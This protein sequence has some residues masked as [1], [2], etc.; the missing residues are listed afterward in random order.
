MP[1]KKTSPDGGKGRWRLGGAGGHSDDS[2]GSRAAF[3]ADDVSDAIAI[4]PANGSASVS[5]AETFDGTA[6]RTYFGLSLEYPRYQLSLLQTP[7][8][9][10]ERRGAKEQGR[11]HDPY[12]LNRSPTTGLQKYIRRNAPISGRT[13]PIC[14]YCSEIVVVFRSNGNPPRTPT[15]FLPRLLAKIDPHRSLHRRD[16]RYYIIFCGGEGALASAND[17]PGGKDGRG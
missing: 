7:R 15:G 9:P 4:S 17:E 12:A 8:L 14:R 16:V 11:I 2:N 5:F 10:S 13:K 6:L 3:R 1:G